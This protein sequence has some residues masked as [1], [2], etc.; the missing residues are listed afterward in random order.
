M[1]IYGC[2]M[3]TKEKKVKDNR[4][5][6]GSG[7]GSN[8]RKF[9]GSGNGLKDGNGRGKRQACPAGQRRRRDGSCRKK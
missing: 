1:K 9:D 5:K 4:K 7:D 2:F 6:D 8:K 3:I